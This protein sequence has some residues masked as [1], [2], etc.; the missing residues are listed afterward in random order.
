MAVLDHE[1]GELEYQVHPGT[2]PAPQ[3]VLLHEG[4]GSVAQWGRLPARLATATG[5]TTL[6]YSRHGYGGSGGRFRGGDDYLLVEADA[7]LPQVLN[8]VGAGTDPVLIGHSDG[9]SIAIA[10]AARRPVRGL[11][12]IA[13]HV[14]VER[15]TID[16]IR[17]A[18]A[19]FEDTLAR[20][21]RPYHD[22]P[23]ALFTAWSQTWLAPSFAAM[24]LTDR[25][26]RID[27]PVLLVQG[28]LD[29]YGT[30]AQLDRI[31]ATAAGPVR[32]AI[33]PGISHHPHVEAATETLELIRDFTNSLVSRD[34]VS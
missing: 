33:L 29:Q 15:R 27:A 9:A 2:A 28:E 7:V 3:L 21:L 17:S 13:P 34:T 11:V 23:L 12:L 32:I 8:R 1:L 14:V 18:A 25:V 30:A 6:S 24:D 19:T 31:A 5:M 10:Y 26:A 16:G 20:S 4:L 22:D